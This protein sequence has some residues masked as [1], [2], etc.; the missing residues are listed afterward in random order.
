[1]IVEFPSVR[2]FGCDKP[3]VND[4]LRFTCMIGSCGLRSLTSATPL[5]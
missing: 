2:H 1:M 4:E 3:F 5:S